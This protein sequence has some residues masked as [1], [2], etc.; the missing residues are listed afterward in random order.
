[1]S[2]YV[3]FAEKPEEF[4]SFPDKIGG[5]PVWV[6]PKNIPSEAELKCGRCDKAMSFLLQV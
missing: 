2:I 6:I 5:K 1:M 4:D 3:G